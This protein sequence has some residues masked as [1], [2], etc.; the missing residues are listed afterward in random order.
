MVF[1]LSCPKQHLYNLDGIGSKA[2]G[3]R[4]QLEYLPKLTGFGQ[5]I[6]ALGEGGEWHGTLSLGKPRSLYMDAHERFLELNHFC[7]NNNKF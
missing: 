3:L 1:G 2:D 7:I 5:G 6:G 4:G